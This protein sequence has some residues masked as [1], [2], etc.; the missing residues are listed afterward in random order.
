MAISH[1][2][3]QT[4]QAVIEDTWKCNH[5]NY[6]IGVFVSNYSLVVETMQQCSSKPYQRGIHDTLR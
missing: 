1:L 5:V 3:K 4:S 6:Y 2:T